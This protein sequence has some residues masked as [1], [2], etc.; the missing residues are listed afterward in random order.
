MGRRSLNEQ[1]W[2]ENKRCFACGEQNELGLQLKI[3][4]QDGVVRARWHPRPEYSNWYGTVHGGVL[5]VALDEIAGSAA[6]L[7]FHRRDG[8]SP[9]LVTAEYTVR[10]TASAR[11]ESTFDCAARV[12]EL[13][14]RAAVVE[15][16][17]RDGDTLVATMEGR[18]VKLQRR[19]V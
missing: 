6:W 14:K 11:V 19:A 8:D 5:T 3:Y 4:E 17:L 2:S 10:F 18:F 1:F 7:E 9:Y 13:D 12:V 16:T 15:G